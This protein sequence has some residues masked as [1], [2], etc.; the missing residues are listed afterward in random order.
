MHLNI[1]P[2]EALSI[3]ESAIGKELPFM[4][5]GVGKKKFFGK[6]KDNTF[7]I[8]QIKDKSGYIRKWIRDPFLYGSI[9]ESGA[10]SRLEI[11]ILVHPFYKIYMVIIF[12]VIA[13]FIVGILLMTPRFGFGMLKGLIAPGILSL[14][15]IGSMYISKRIR[16]HTE[17]L[18]ATEMI[19]FI[20]HIFTGYRK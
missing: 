18:Q 17:R 6:I 7:R 5:F 9:K 11:E 2:Q 3:L 13:F 15:I 10:G 4:F 8:Q 1:P 20:D 14:L 19:K 16:R 12:G